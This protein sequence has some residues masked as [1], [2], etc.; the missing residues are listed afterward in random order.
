MSSCYEIQLIQK[1]KENLADSRELIRIN[2]QISCLTHCIRLVTI[3]PVIELLFEALGLLYEAK[4]N[5]VKNV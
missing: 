1:T 4:S 2:D 5:Y 3:E